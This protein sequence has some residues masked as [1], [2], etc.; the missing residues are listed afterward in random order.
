MTDSQPLPL[1]PPTWEAAEGGGL[2]LNIL[3]APQQF[4]LLCNSFKISCLKI[5]NLH[6]SG[7]NTEN[8]EFLRNLELAVYGSQYAGLVFLPFLVSYY[9]LNFDCFPIISWWPNTWS[10][11]PYRCTVCLFAPQIGIS[12]TSITKINIR[13]NIKWEIFYTN[14]KVF[15]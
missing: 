6:K 1:L 3:T 2:C 5:W 10:P 15:V 14:W 7:L 9:F 11:W 8:Y 13:I 12:W 4:F